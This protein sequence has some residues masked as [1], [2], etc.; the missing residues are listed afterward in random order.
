ML[1]ITTNGPPD[2]ARAGT[3]G[4]HK[5][6]AR[7]GRFMLGCIQYTVQE[8]CSCMEKADL[9]EALKSAIQTEKDAMDY[10]NFAAQKA[11]DGRVKKTFELLGREERQ[12]ALTFYNAY[13]DNDLPSF[14][15]LMAAPPNTGS[16]WWKSLQRTLVGD[17]DE[18]LALELAIEQEEQLE[19]QLR[20]AAE[21][22]DDAKVRDIYL[23][24]ASS[25]HQ[26]LLLVEE[27]YRGLLGQSS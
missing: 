19:K 6:L 23:A 24:N 2:C 12:H 3:T 14:D 22:I 20:A 16:S 13:P 18:R 25:T 1:T 21:K 8:E 11:F 4:R 17:F 9:K 5:I 15:E 26:H 7:A 10:Y 27:D